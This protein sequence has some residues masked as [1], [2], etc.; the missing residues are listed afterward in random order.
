[1]KKC[2]VFTII[3][4]FLLSAS[5]QAETVFRDLSWGDTLDA[6][7]DT[8]E[9]T[10]SEEQPGIKM[11]RRSNEDLQLGSYIVS[12]VDYWFFD[13]QLMRIVVWAGSNDNKKEAEGLELMLNAKY[14]KARGTLFSNN[15][16]WTHNDTKVLRI[17]PL[18]GTV[19]FYLESIPI[20]EQY[21]AWLDEY[22]KKQAAANADAW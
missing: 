4:V 13:D 8:F 22:K 12:S 2:Y 1:M 16:E 9:I 7:G 14:G 6:L 21:D 3:A 5:V 19:H 11:V 15:L 17:W 10:P 20:R 18:F